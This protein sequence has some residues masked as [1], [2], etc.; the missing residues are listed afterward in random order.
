MDQNKIGKFIASCRKEKGLTQ[1]QLA[2]RLNISNRAVSKWETGKSMPDVS[3]MQKLC[4]E[5]DISVNDLLSGERIPMEDYRD[6]AEENLLELQ[7]ENLL[8][9][10]IKR[11]INSGIPPVLQYLIVIMISALL[12][13]GS[14]Y[15][16]F[17]DPEEGAG[18][19]IFEIIFSLGIV[20]LCVQTCRNIHRK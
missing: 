18:A 17:F 8:E 7:Q 13:F 20:V 12:L 19:R 4:S 16:L 11:L 2:E 15:L 5:L 3:V 6:K 1:M 9:R 10:A 14:L